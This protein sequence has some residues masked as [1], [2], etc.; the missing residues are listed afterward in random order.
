MPLKTGN[1]RRVAKSRPVYMGLYSYNFQTC[2]PQT[3]RN[4]VSRSFTIIIKSCDF[5]QNREIFEISQVS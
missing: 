3:D 4:R 1:S 2:Q 5:V